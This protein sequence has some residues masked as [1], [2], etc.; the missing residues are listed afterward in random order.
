MKHR[1]FSIY[2]TKG[3]FHSP[4]F[5]Q[6]TVGMAIRAFKDTA[7]DRNTTIAAHPEDFIL[8]SLGEFE[9]RNGTFDI[10]TPTAIMHANEE[11]E[12]VL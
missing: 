11:S 7:A 9:D 8:F 12:E 3:E 4:P 1:I 2:D 10:Q 6:K 5:Y